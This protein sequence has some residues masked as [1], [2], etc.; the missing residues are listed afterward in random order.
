L[1]GG[2]AAIR[3]ELVADLFNTRLDGTK[4][5]PNWKEYDEPKWFPVFDMDADTPS[6]VGLSDSDCD[7][8]NS[9]TDCGSRFAFEKKELSNLA[10]EMYPETFIESL[11]K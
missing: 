8:W 7:D 11:T 2:R 5:I 4:W 9:L 3:K 10:V 6:G 1:I